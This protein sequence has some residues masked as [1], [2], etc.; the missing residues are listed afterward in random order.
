VIAVTSRN[1]LIDKDYKT[2]YRPLMVI[3]FLLIVL[4][5]SKQL[6][7]IMVGYDKTIIP[8][9]FC[10]FFNLLYPLA[11][12]SKGRVKQVSQVMASVYSF[13][14]AMGLYLAPAMMIGE[15]AY[16]LF[17]GFLKLHTFVYHHLVVMYAMLSV[18]LQLVDIELKDD[19]LALLGGAALYSIIG[20][21]SS[22][23]LKTNFHNFYPVNPGAFLTMRESLGDF[24]YIFIWGGAFVLAVIPSFFLFKLTYNIVGKRPI[25]EQDNFFNKTLR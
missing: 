16:N 5:G 6:R 20:G 1:H 17:G 15:S 23:A 21:L 14:V 3:A 19:L 10:S 11:I 24:L 7:G 22:I 8:L 9:Y 2:R 4:D 18:S 25:P 12:Y 13:M